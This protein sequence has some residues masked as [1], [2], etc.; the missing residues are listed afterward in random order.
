M[1][2]SINFQ[3]HNS[4]TLDHD[5]QYFG[6]YLNMARLNIYNISNHLA[7]KFGIPPIPNEDR[8]NSSFFVDKKNSKFKNKQ[9][10]IFSHLIRYMP[11]V[12]IFDSEK[13][14]SDEIEE[15]QN[16]FGRDFNEL[17]E[18]LK[19]VFSEINEFRNDYSHYYSTEK[20]NNR[21]R[22]VSNKLKEFLNKNHQRAIQYTKARFKEVFSENDFK[23]ANETIVVK[24][25]NTITQDGI[26]FLTSMFLD[27]ENAFQ[28]IN[29]ITG[30]K[31]T[32]TKAFKAKRE[33][34]MSFCVKLPHD[35]FVSEDIKQAFS[36]ELINELNKCPKILYNVITEKEKQHFIPKLEEEQKENVIKYS[37]LDTI[38]D[39]EEYIESITKKVRNENRFSY[40][41]LKFIDL[42]ELF[43]NWRF[44][45]DLGKV[46][47]AEYPKQLK[48]IDETRTIVENAKAFGRLQNMINEEKVL[49]H[50]NTSE[51]KT[52]F[53]QFAPHYN[54]NNN[55]IGI[56]SKEQTSKFISK[57]TN[58]KIK[59]NLIQQPPEAFLSIHEL[60]KIILLE[61]LQKGKTEQLINDF[62]LIN[63]S[64]ILNK[65]FIESIKSQLS[66]FDVFYKRSQKR[67]E[68]NAYQTNTLD[69]L[70]D[71]KNKLDQ[72]LIKYY[73]NKKQ[74][75]SRILDYWLNIADIQTKT[76]ISDRIKLMKR[77]CMDRIKNL[78]KGKAPRIGE[79]AT[80]LAKDIVDMI[81]G[82]EKKQKITS[83][84]Y[85]KMQECLALY[86]D[87]DK[88]ELFIHI[89][90][91]ELKLN[92][93]DG[94]PFLKNIKLSDLHYTSD[95]YKNYL[96][97]KADTRRNKKDKDYSWMAKTFY[98]IE[99]TEVYNKKKK[100]NEIKDNTIVI[101]PQDKTLIPFTLQQ[102]EKEKSS[103]D[104]WLENITFDNKKTIRKKPVDLPTNLFDDP[105][106]ELLKAEL[107]NK[108]IAF[109]M[110]AN[111]NTL[112]KIWWA[113][114]RNDSMQ[115]FYSAEREYNFENETLTFSINTKKHFSEYLNE[116]FVQA[117][118][119]T[120]N[121]KRK[122]QY[123][124]LPPLKEMD[125]TK[126][127]GNNI[128]NREKE[129]RIIQEEDRMMLL[130]F[131]NL[132]KKNL[133]LKLK[134]IET[135][136]NESVLIKQTIPC[137]LLYDDEG[138]KVIKPNRK[139]ITKNI[140]E[141]RK[142]KEYSV[143]KKYV[144]DRR[145]PELF[146]YFEEE[147]IPMEKIK[148]ELDAY[149]KAKDVIFD[150]VF[151]LEKEIIHKYE[152]HI[153]ALN[154]DDNGNIISGHILHKP[155]LFWLL[156]N[157]IITKDEYQ[158]MYMIR[159]SF[160]HNQFPQKNT[161]QLFISQWSK[162]NFALQIIDIYK[163]KFDILKLKI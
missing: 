30:L 37:V 42:N 17:S 105:L 13:L 130:M 100:I 81:I 151:K 78:K 162:T 25:D 40:F 143:L 39:Y 119:S 62:I 157:N 67:K 69:N 56:S 74:I 76:A 72:I 133:D 79:M 1:E 65:E 152:H 135:L 147:D 9:N 95:L 8:I 145:L 80:F 121:E 29:K 63:E 161:M 108:N 27:R 51:H 84:Y 155:Y 139:S 160:S 22:E 114:L 23:I 4:R 123:P 98:N 102:L 96:E 106:E 6:S 159:N 97:V 18:T 125:V 134:N 112:F 35:K 115:H 5:P 111:W 34:M 58:S 44:Q 7:E 153:K 31:G 11:I 45:I 77:D 70:H 14:P 99:E 75:P 103:L 89:C 24:N 158:F 41:V 132:T 141:T 38:D 138:K 107:K 90:N 87:P 118:L 163:Q 61:Y 126:T 36:L 2:N 110:D 3:E 66:E 26:V 149:S 32:Q 12:K 43:Q 49:L 128:A 46:V 83:F 122:N 19:I 10:H 86:A 91:N 131:E 101:L 124:P 154:K 21:K 48:G 60:P 52:H 94:H 64:K 93:I 156:D 113:E 55:K 148:L 71:R 20:Q 59:F 85:D 88:K 16:N 109:E 50:I 146:E 137:K 82:K 144:N 15:N 73:L 33:V 57:N 120:K 129:I 116:K 142:R 140:T 28:F 136:L 54:I 68:K 117:V 104:K 53:E 150:L 127:I 47:L 92:D